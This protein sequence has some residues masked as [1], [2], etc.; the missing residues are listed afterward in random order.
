L[1]LLVTLTTILASM[2]GAQELD[3]R[4]GLLDQ[5]QKL[6]QRIDRL[7]REQELLLFQKTA[8]QSDSKYL[9]LDARSGKGLMKYRN[10]TLRSFS[11]ARTD[12]S[13]PRPKAGPRILSEKIEGPGK[14]SHS[15]TL[16]FGADVIVRTKRLVGEDRIPKGASSLTI[17]TKDMAALYHAMEKGAVLYVVK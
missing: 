2:A 7:R 4:Q 6:V 1:F 13:S 12:R 8:Y 9:L 3:E 17:S 14:G 15:R 11:I 5:R 16:V 10:R